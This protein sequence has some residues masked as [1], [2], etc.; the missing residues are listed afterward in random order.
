MP[1][2]K[3]SELIASVKSLNIR[4]INK[5]IIITNHYSQIFPLAPPSQ[6]FCSLKYTQ[7]RLLRVSFI[8]L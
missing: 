1:K 4:Y 7:N 3:Q 6:L 5:Y 8:E 2:N